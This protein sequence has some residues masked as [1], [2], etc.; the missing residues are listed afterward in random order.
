MSGT[1][2]TSGGR[3]GAVFDRAERTARPVLGCWTTMRPGVAR[4]SPCSTSR[5]RSVLWN[6]ASACDT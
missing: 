5:N 3:T 2:F 6:R 1:Y 4:P